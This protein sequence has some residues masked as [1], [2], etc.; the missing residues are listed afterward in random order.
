M[1]T[2]LFFLVELAERWMLPWHVSQRA[3]ATGH[4]A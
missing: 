2:V 1:G 4:H 3:E